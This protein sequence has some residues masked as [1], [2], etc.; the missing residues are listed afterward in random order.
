MSSQQARCI[1][2]PWPAG[3]MPLEFGCE[4]AAEDAQQEAHRLGTRYCHF[5]TSH[6]SH[7]MATSQILADGT[8]HREAC[9]C[10]IGAPPR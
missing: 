2:L 9:S 10:L 3:G 8:W 4:Y 7:R 5:A 6:L 1:R